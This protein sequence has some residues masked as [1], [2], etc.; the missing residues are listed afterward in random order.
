MLAASENNLI[1]DEVIFDEEALKAYVHHL[2]THT[3]YYIGVFCDLAVMQER[4]I[5]RRDRCIDLSNDQID[6]VHQSVLNS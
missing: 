5:L 3:V 2:K 1:I 6:R 4:K